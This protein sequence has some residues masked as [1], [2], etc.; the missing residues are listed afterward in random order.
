MIIR[1][2]LNCN[3]TVVPN[4]PIN[5]ARLSFKAI[6]LLVYLLSRPDHWNVHIEHLRQRGGI[7][8]EKMQGLIR[9]LIKHG[10]IVRERHRASTTNRFGAFEYVVYD[11]PNRDNRRNF[12]DRRS[13]PATENPSVGK[14][15]K[16]GEPQTGKPATENPS[17]GKIRKIGEPQTGKPAT[18]NPSVIV[19][20]D[21]SNS[22]RE[23]SAPNGAGAEAPTVGKMVWKEAIIL[24][25]PFLP[26]SRYRSLIGKWFKRAKTLENQNKLLA[27]VRST[28]RA[29]TLDPVPY[30]EAAINA[31]LPLPPDPA[32]LSNEEWKLRVTVALSRKE[33]SGDW[34][35]PPG[36]R[37]CLLPPSMIKPELLSAVGKIE[38][39]RNA[40]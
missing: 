25:S 19:S 37:K 14:I 35:P 28:A 2:K 26:E 11:E 1:R 4:E 16:I 3:Y 39:V 8:R 7:G 38:A 15:R 12:A 5:D 13:K 17:V 34:G 33:W 24:L 27:A 22:L 21:S 6:G 36:H 23:S 9:D 20:T 29:G 31:A 18:E 10:Y 40:A 32:T 30:L